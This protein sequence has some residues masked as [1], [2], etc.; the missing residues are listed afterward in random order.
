MAPAA[1]GPKILGYDAAGVV[2]ALGSEVSRFKVSDEVYYW[3]AFDRPGTNAEYHLFDE[4][5]AGRK[6]FSLT[7]AESEAL[8]FTA[9]T[10][11]E[12]LFD[13]LRILSKDD[14]ER[15]TLLV[16]NGA[17]GVGS[18]LLQLARQLT[19]H[20]HAPAATSERLDHCKGEEYCTHLAS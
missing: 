9:L 8:P 16:I 12:L 2:E 14:T 3:G 15:R 20:A 10:A 17:G 6:P 11:W 13:R 7:F 5:L 18:I 4:R 19:S 1:A